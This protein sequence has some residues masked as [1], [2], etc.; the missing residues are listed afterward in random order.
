MNHVIKFDDLTKAT[1]KREYDDGLMD[2]IFGGAFLLLCLLNWYIFSSFGLKWYAT[3]LIQNREITIIASITLIPLLLLS[4]YGARKMVGR[5]RQKTLWKNQGFV[6]PLRW[7]VSR[8]ISLMAGAVLI[9]MIII[10]A[11]LMMNGSTSQATTLRTLVSSMGVS[12]GMVFY[13]M[14]KELDL[15]RYQWIGTAGGMLS[16]LI[17]FTPLSFSGSW[18]MLGVAWMVVF[19]VSG[20]WALRKSILAIREQDSE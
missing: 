16:L 5:I 2:Y 12:T 6:K 15:R 1:R 11:W 8:H 4:I 17:I 20:S 7:Q 9:A 13:G 18:L 14:G 10:A 19:G 3:R